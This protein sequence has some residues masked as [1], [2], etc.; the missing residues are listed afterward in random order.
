MGKQHPPSTLCTRQLPR[1]RKIG[2]LSRPAIR[3]QQPTSCTPS[4]SQFR[5]IVTLVPE[6]LSKAP[7][8]V[9][10][11]VRSSFNAHCPGSVPCYDRGGC[12]TRHPAGDVCATIR[13]VARHATCEV[14]PI[15]LCILC[16]WRDTDLDSEWTCKRTGSWTG[17]RCDRYTLSTSGAVTV[18]DPASTSS[19]QKQQEFLLN[20]STEARWRANVGFD[21]PSECGSCS[22]NVTE[23]L[24]IGTGRCSAFS[25]NIFR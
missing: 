10:E 19:L 12:A 14:V 17:A 11:V 25:H 13:L 7:V 16:A 15:V 4:F 18:F 8:C 23:Q 24:P 9:H 3:P 22:G 1:T 21:L 5:V 20:I 6:M 2:C